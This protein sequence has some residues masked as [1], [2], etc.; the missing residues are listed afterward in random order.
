MRLTLSAIAVVVAAVTTAGT[1]LTT[2]TAA[3]APRHQH[4]RVSG[5]IQPCPV[6][7]IDAKGPRVFPHS[8]DYDARTG[9]FVVGSLAHSTISTVGRDGTVRTLVDDKDLVSVQAV[10]V[11]SR[12]HRVLATNVDYGLADRSAP[13]TKLS[14]AGVASYDATTGRRHWYV[15]L[16]KVADDGKQHLLADV[17]VAPDGTAYAVDQ[18]TPTVFRIDRHGR[19]SVLLRND[20]L[21]GTVDIPDF[22]TG[23]GQTAVAW[24]PGDVLIIAKADGSLVR[25]PTRHPEQA[26]AVRL[27]GKLAALTA[28]LRVLPDGSLAA[29]SS[30]LLSGKAA[31]VQRV[32]PVDHWTSAAVT[33]TDTV[34]DP[35]TSGV[36]AGPR[37]STYALSGG[38]AALLMGK[39]NDGFTLRPVTVK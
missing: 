27:S 4:I 35:V 38:L 39:P 17:T 12:R 5:D 25:V 19:A 2:T 18:L 8:V 30:G 3:H 10:R 34:T 21:A 6:H 28:G 32:R 13:S 26:G 16:N 24:M 23:V 9:K 1:A 11:D 14:V 20:L 36:S 37:G 7:T 33:V 15:D 31:V 22:L 29:V